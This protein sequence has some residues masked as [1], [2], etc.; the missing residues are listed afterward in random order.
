MWMKFIA[1][2]IYVI[3]MLVMLFVFSE[4]MNWGIFIGI[5]IVYLIADFIIKY[6]LNKDRIHDELK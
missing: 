2:I 1:T 4:I 3:V 5:T 6:Q